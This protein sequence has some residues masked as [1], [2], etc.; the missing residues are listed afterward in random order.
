MVATVLVADDDTDILRFVEINLRLEGFQV[1]TAQDGPEALAKAVTG[2]PHPP[3]RA[4]CPRR[5]GPGPPRA[6]RFARLIIGAP[7]PSVA[8]RSQRSASWPTSSAWRRRP[9]RVQSS[10]RGRA[11]P[12]KCRS[13][14]VVVQRGASREA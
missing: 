8:T 1:V 9:E 13:G 10:H 12:V 5:K 14:P 4:P 7:A 11:L 6:V 3:L 2:Q